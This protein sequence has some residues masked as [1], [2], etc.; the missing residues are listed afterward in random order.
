MKLDQERSEL[1]SARKIILY[2][3]I[4]IVILT[5]TMFLFL[6]HSGRASFSESKES[7]IKVMS[8]VIPQLTLICV[9]FFS[10]KDKKLENRIV[11][12][13]VTMSLIY[14]FCFVFLLYWGVYFEN[15]ESQKGLDLNMEAFTVYIGYISIIGISPI[16]YLFNSEK[17]I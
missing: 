3:W 16:G 17:D 14:Q 1:F 7:L 6:N 11:K 8:L 10:S 2:G 5:I 15:F 9:F 12:L 4:I 13:C